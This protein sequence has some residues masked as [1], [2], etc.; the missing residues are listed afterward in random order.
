M[1]TNDSPRE[2]ASS[3]TGLTAVVIV[4][5]TAMIAGVAIVFVLLARRIQRHEQL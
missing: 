1:A 2:T 3:E 5:G 4:V